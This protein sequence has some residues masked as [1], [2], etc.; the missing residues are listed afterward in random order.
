MNSYKASWD[1]VLD[2]ENNIMGVGIVVR[3]AKGEVIAALC[4]KEEDVS[5]PLIATTRALWLAINLCMETG[6]K[7]VIFEGDAKKIVEEVNNSEE[8]WAPHGQ[9]IEVIQS[10]SIRYSI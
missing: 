10:F 6:L 1:A 3:N 4:N 5:S 7:D 2:K 9:L 8:N